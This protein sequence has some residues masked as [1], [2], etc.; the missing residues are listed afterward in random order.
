MTEPHYRS[1]KICYVE[2]PATDVAQSSAFYQRAFGWEVR[3][4]GDGSTAFDDTVHE[5]SGTWVTG[6]RPVGE[7]SLTVYVM[8]GNAAKAADAV[9][10]AGGEIVRPVDPGS[11]E[12]HFLFRDPAGNVMG[13]YQQ[14]GLEEAEAAS[15][16]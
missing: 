7:G 2:I 8:V 10:A 12:V 11:R 14:R 3:Q 6:R 5:V 9:V 16:R 1:G 4:R 15:G 13:V